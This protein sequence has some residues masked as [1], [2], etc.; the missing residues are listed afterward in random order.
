MRNEFTP[1]ERF[2]QVIVCNPPRALLRPV[3]GVAGNE[4]PQAKH[5]LHLLQ[6]T[7]ARKYR[8]QNQDV[9]RSGAHP[10]APRPARNSIRAASAISWPPTPPAPNDRPR[11]LA[12]AFSSNAV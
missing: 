12:Y 1:I 7:D 9:P 10:V 11:K 8:H 5:G 4:D 3:I 6:Q 2:G